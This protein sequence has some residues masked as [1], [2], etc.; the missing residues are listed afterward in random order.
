M[1]EKDTIVFV[2]GDRPQVQHVFSEK[3]NAHR[4]MR[5]AL[6]EVCESS[7]DSAILHVVLNQ[8]V[9]CLTSR[10]II[11]MPKHFHPIRFKPPAERF[12]L[13]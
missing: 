10:I 9:C 3:R 7:S 5:Y 4:V 11:T 2:C 1:I 8:D 13:E 12:D 6:Q